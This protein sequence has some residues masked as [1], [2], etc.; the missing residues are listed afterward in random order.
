[1]IQKSVYNLIIIIN[2]LLYTFYDDLKMSIIIKQ[3]R[4]RNM[5]I[6]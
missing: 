6:T 4:Y 1:M 5:S 2:M 3:R